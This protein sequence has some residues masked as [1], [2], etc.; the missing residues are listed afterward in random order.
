MALTSSS[1]TPPN[2]PAR[3]RGMANHK[4]A[5]PISAKK[6]AMDDAQM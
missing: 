6:S 5:P 3:K 4:I 2:S 1:K